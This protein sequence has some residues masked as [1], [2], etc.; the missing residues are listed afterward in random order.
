MPDLKEIKESI[1]KLSPEDFE[2]LRRWIVEKHWEVW[3]KQIEEDSQAGKLDFLIEEAER[4][5]KE[6]KLLDL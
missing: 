1:E 3:D 6:G 5:F 4:E 2:K